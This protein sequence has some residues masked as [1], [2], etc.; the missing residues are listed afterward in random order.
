MARK[1]RRKPL[2]FCNGNNKA[3]MDDD[4]VTDSDLDLDDAQVD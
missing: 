1:T 3:L 4:I 2:I